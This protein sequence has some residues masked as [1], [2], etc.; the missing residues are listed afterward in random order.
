MDRMAPDAAAIDAIRDLYDDLQ[1]EGDVL[2]LGGFGLDHFNV[3]PDTLTTERDAQDAFDAVIY[4]GAPDDGE[5]FADVAQALKPGGMFV[6][7]FTNETAPDTAKHV[8]RL[9]RRFD[10][11]PGFGPAESDLRTSL[12]GAGDQLWAVWAT[13]R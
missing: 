3:P 8:R 10:T 9:R 12:T 4:F 1:I 2:D 7:T 5:L 11:T 13:K 6:T